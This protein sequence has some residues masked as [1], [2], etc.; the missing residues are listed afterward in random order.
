MPIKCSPTRDMITLDTLAMP[1]DE[2]PTGLKV[3]LLRSDNSSGLRTMILQ[4]PPRPISA[5]KPHRHTCSEELFNLG[6][7]M[8]FDEGQAIDPY[9]FMLYPAG[10]VHGGQI[11]LPDGY[12]LLVHTPAAAIIEPVMAG[13]CDISTAPAPVFIAK[14]SEYRWEPHCG[15]SQGRATKARLSWNKGT[16]TGSYLLKVPA[17]EVCDLSHGHRAAEI[18]V[19]RGEIQFSQSGRISPQGFAYGHLGIATAGTKSE[20]LAHV[21]L[22]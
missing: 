4:S 6:P 3:K 17:G 22:C 14:P 8:Q 20:M 15:A 19:L 13:R 11:A 10:T 5:Q 16:G 21:R 1:W 2:K 9:G 18:F 12:H 7:R